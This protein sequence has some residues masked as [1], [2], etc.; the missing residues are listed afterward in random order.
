MPNN[1]E[2][3][4]ILKEKLKNKIT[5]SQETEQKMQNII[6]EQKQK[7]NNKK[8]SK[9][10]RMKL[11]VSFAAV[12]LI[13]FMLG[14]Y[15]KNGVNFEEKTITVATIKDIKPTK[16]NNEILAKDSEFLIYAEG[17]DLT[18]ESVQKAIYIQP[19]LEYTIK[20]TS[21]SNEYKLTFKQN[22]PDNT[23]VKLE[24]VKDQITE[25]SWAYQT[26]NELS[27]SGTYPSDRATWVPKNTVIEIEFSYAT[28]ENLQEN[29]EISPA[30][31]GTWE[32]LGKVWR[33][34][35][36]QALSEGNYYVKVK[37]GIIA[38]QKTLKNDY[39]FNFKVYEVFREEIKYNT[40]S[41]DEINT[42]KPDEPVRIYCEGYNEKKLEISKLEIAKFTNKDDFI[43]YL[44]NKNYQKA[45]E[46]SEYKFDQTSKYIQLT[47]GLQ[48]GY[49]VAI[50]YGKNKT[51]IL[52]CPI[53]INELSAYA[54]STERDVLVWVAK[55]DDL[56]QDIQVQYQGKVQKTNNQGI[57]EFKNIADDSEQ[58]KYLSL[59]NTQNELVVGIYNYDL[60]NYPTAYLY[61]DRPLYKN[62]DKI[63]IWGFV[64]KN[65]FF[66]KLEDE[67]YIELNSEG[68]QKVKVEEE[69]SLNYSIN[70]NNHMDE[71]Y[72]SI[73]LY[74]KD[75][76][77]ARRSFSIE[78]Y[79]AQ[80]YTYE[81]TYNKNY[82]YAGT[83]FEFDV[84]INHITGLVVPNKMVRV[85]CGSETYRVASNEN[86]IAHFSINISNE[87]RLW[88]GASTKTIQIY[89]GDSE[90]YTG[91]EQYM[92]V[93][94]LTKDVYTETEFKDNKYV[95]TLHK[96][97]GNK[98]TNIGYDL[99]NIYGEKYN[100]Q[101][102]VKLEETKWERQINGY[103]YNE[104]TKQNE[105]Q[106][107]YVAKKNMLQ[108]K[109]VNTQNGTIEV[110]KDELS[111]KAPTETEYYNYMLIYAYKDQLGRAVE[112]TQYVATEENR[113]TTQIGYYWDDAVL[114]GGEYSSDLLWNASNRI[115]QSYYYTYRYFLK[116]QMEKFSIGDTTSFEL[117]ES[118][119][120]GNKK[121][122]NEGKIL[123]LV[124]Q[125]DITKKDI[126]TNDE[127]NYTFR[128]EDF[129]GCKI[130]T[131]YFY[132]GNFYRMPIYYFDFDEQ[133]R[134][135]DVEITAD[136]KEYKPG[137]EVTLTIKTTNN[138]K[139]LKSFVNISVVN[140]AVFAITEDTTNILTQIYKDKDYP[141]YTYS[142]YIDYIDHLGMRWRRRRR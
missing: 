69:G 109:T 101:V 82:A 20:K 92:T 89:N 27:V 22:I 118:T 36:A 24:Y 6:K 9:Y 117:N 135:V 41:I 91:K 112:D 130:T 25:D 132:K 8:V 7:A 58:I 29:V 93:Y 73:K 116:Y 99:E 127:L 129:P 34:T 52:N 26:A 14:I 125:E 45:T 95:A 115:S 126:I 46:K 47:K 3:D 65:L 28:V 138:G 39:I 32:H 61:T 100:T 57:A 51:E 140:E 124:L 107:S 110:K 42:F 120:D 78:N 4:K 54:V 71:Q 49:Y 10:G 76:I 17:E 114:E 63:N 142:S 106:Y 16:S 90:E 66:D 131:A 48:N 102:I 50:I 13:V 12:T 23:I 19:A 80:N 86:G 77:I 104:Y 139:A 79:E 83:K 68:K 121:I 97:N 11:I 128:E 43:E 94:V 98:N 67:F 35:P 5:L 85:R 84:K 123:R 105:P 55:G 53:Q 103:K 44:Q 72:A 96:L 122:K 30:I 134:K 62:T 136:K 21:N 33:F 81:I 113:T 141:I 133:D 2:I 88:S 108:V 87:D 59:G 37:K 31:N 75:E 70:L 111:L 64:P 119:I 74:Y 60:D 1:D 15:F 18:V 40:I 56:A 137:E 38:E